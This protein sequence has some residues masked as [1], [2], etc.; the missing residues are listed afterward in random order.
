M[1]P[2]GSVLFPGVVLPLQ[3]FEDRYR[4]LVSDIEKGDRR[5]GVVLIERGQE[6]GGGDER[7]D[8]GTVAEILQRGE[9]EE[10]LIV[11]VAVGRERVRVKRWLEDAPYPLAMVEPFPEPS[12]EQDI[13]PAIERCV[14]ARSRLLALAIEMGVIDQGLDLELPEEPGQAAW[15]LCAAAPLGPF[16]RQQLLT[17]PDAATRLERLEQMLISQ[18]QDLE[19]VL[20]RD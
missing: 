16:D 20:R 1:F 9:T 10:G 12:A 14:A 15:A 13:A 17:I 11:I 6:V 18:E 4:A 7:S 3:V 19:A 8:V 2:L 5:F